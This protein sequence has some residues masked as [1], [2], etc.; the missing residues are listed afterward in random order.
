MSVNEITFGMKYGTSGRIDERIRSIFDEKFETNYLSILGLTI[1]PGP[2]ST[3]AP[4]LLCPDT[5]SCGCS[6]TCEGSTYG[7][8]C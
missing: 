8:D 4:T 1:T 3:G 5:C 6:I 7:C 2:C